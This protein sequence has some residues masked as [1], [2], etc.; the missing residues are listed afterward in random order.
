MKRHRAAELEKEV[1]FTMGRNDNDTGHFSGL[2]LR[3][4]VIDGQAEYKRDGD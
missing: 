1:G 4:C 2:G 3:D